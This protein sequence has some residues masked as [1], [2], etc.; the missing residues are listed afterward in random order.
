MAESS[1]ISGD[2]GPEGLARLPHSR[3]LRRPARF[4]EIPGTIALRKAAVAADIAA[5][6]HPAPVGRVAVAAV[7]PTA[8]AD[9]ITPATAVS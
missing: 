7:E 1:E 3:P 9:L 6:L 5:L 4:V 8:V 2:L